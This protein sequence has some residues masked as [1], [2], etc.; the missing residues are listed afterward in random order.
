MST[1]GTRK[2]GAVEHGV[3]EL[4]DAAERM[5]E[6]LGYEGL[7]APEAARRAGV[8]LDGDPPSEWELF[9]AVI[10]RDEDRFNAM[11]A[12]AV[13]EAETAGERLVALIEAC[14]VDY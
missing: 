8:E 13:A 10:R 6:E 5:I 4:L 2:G 14:V 1:G 11:V 3:D 7:S 12:D 9:A